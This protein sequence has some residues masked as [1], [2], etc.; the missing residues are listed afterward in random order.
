MRR[1]ISRALFLPI[2]AAALLARP[3][4]PSATA[5][6][7]E[8]VVPKAEG[9]VLDGKGLDAGWEG[10]L[11]IPAEA[12]DGKT[13]TVRVL[14][15]GGK[16][17]F[18]A[19]MP[20]DV[21]FPVGL[22]A[23][24]CADGT[25]TAADA[26]QAAYGPQEVRGP[27]YA[28]RG[29]KGVGRTT[30][31]FEG[32]ADVA[33]LGRWSVEASIPVE[34][35]ALPSDTT[36]I[37][38]A[39]VVM[40]RQLNRFSTA[41]VGS[42]FQAPTTFAKLSP[43]E[44]GWSSAGKAVVDADRLAKE[45][46]ADAT[47]MTAWREFVDVQRLGAVQASEARAKLLAPLDRVLAARPDLAMVYVVRGN[48]L[49]ELQDAD[50]ARAA[51]AAALAAVPHMPEA[52]WALAAFDIARFSEGPDTMPSDYP[53]A[54][55]RIAA[56]AKARGGS[57]IAL[58][59]AEGVLRYRLGE[60]EAAIK[61]LEP[62]IK[63]YPVDE[64]LASKLTFSQ[65]YAPLWA[66]E[67]GMRQADAKKDDLPRARV[68]TSRGAFVVELFEDDAPNTVKNFVWL[69]RHGFWEGL[70]FHR[71]IPF[72]MTQGG[73][74]FSPSGDPRLGSGGPGYAIRTEPS[75]R[76][77]FRGMIAMA[78]A[79][80]DSEGSQFFLTT[81]T[82]A[83]LE[84]SFSIFGRVI[85]GQDVVDSLVR[86]DKI[87]NV[88]IVRVREHDYRPTTVAGKPAP[89]PVFPPGIAKPAKPN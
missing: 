33:S 24:L 69:A 66:Q 86:G 60:F 23:L 14:L 1:S 20:E 31:R 38:V 29:P 10:A 43:P 68:V 81:G 13:P 73:D 42:S 65:K 25:A 58:E 72:F 63:G 22:K 17:W 34:D 36:P 3:T 87:V 2:A 11:A 57:S 6:P 4:P 53:A 27:R 83:H 35:L 18:L 41:P 77:P 67:L 26:V 8:A 79:G 46:L 84:G 50:G 28:L 5:G 12:V 48:I 16:L 78:N 54:F 70:L 45:D 71:V 37:R 76:L 59:A 40:T 64:E 19:E 39:L 74:P 55:A 85:E 88:E 51:Y 82:S 80:K 62:V 9:L 47:R 30:Y 75:R 21:G 49:Q 7:L 15:S 52:A 89:E 32:A 61:L 44:G 56:E